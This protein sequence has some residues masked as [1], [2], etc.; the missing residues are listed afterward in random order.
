[1][2]DWLMV[3]VVAFGVLVTLAGIQLGINQV[4]G[5]LNRLER[6]VDMLLRQFNIDPV[7]QLS[8]RVKEIARD[9]TKKIYAI[10]AYRE[11]TGAG[12]LEAK[13]AI[14]EYLRKPQS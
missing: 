6:K 1:M 2:T 7:P 4:I 10:K 9:P 12:L 13:L 3:A 8:D 14:E 5:R 11:E